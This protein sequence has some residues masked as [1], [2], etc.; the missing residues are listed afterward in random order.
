M[1]GSLL[2]H[3]AVERLIVSPDERHLSPERWLPLQRQLRA[4]HSELRTRLGPTA[5]PRTVY[6]LVANPLACTLGFVALPASR[7]A[8]GHGETVDAELRSNGRPVAVMVATAWDRPPRLMWRHCVHRALAHGV[9]WAICVNG[10]SVCLFDGDR[11]YSRRFL[12]LHLPSALDSDRGATVLCGLLGAHGLSAAAPDGAALERAI[13]HS[14]RYRSMVRLSLRAGVSQ[15]V[16]DLISAFRAVPGRPAPGGNGQV[17]EESLIVVYRMLFMLFAEARGLVPSWHPVYRDSYSVAGLREVVAGGEP[18][19]VWET[20]QALARLAHRGCAAGTLMV[21]P[22]NGRLFSPVH[23]PLA[24]TARLDDRTV[25]SAVRAL[26]TRVERGRREEIA[27]GDLGVE[28]LGAVYEHLLDF[29]VAPGTAATATMVPTGRRKATGS[30]YTPRPLTE[31]VVRRVLGPVVDGRA[32]E[33]ILALRIL[34]PAMGSGA[35]LVAAC[36][37]LSTAY[38]AAL[39]RDGVLGAEDLTESDRAGFRR[40][41]AQRCL[42]GV[43]MNPMAVQLARLSL[44]LATLA[45]DK[46]LTFL[47]HRLRVGNSLIGASVDDLLREPVSRP[48]GRPRPLPLFPEDHLQSRLRTAVDVRRGLAEIP[49]DSL[50]QVRAKERNLAALDAAGGPLEKWRTAADLWCAAYLDAA[51]AEKGVFGALRD[52]VFTGRS[53]LP[54]HVSAPLAGRLSAAAAKERAFHWTM[55]FPEVFYDE[56]GAPLADGGFDVVLGN[57]PWEMLRGDAV[58]RA[59][60]IGFVK[61]SGQ[62]RLQGDGHANMYQLFVERAL[63]LLRSAGSCG[64]ILPSGFASDQGSAALRRHVFGRTAVQTFTIVDNRDGLFPIHRALKFLLLTFRAPG[65]T[66]EVPMR[67]GVRSAD[68]LERIADNGVDPEAISVPLALVERVSGESLAVPDLRAEIDLRIL[69]A[70]SLRTPASADAAGWGLRF[71]RELNASDDRPHFNSSGAGLPVIEGKHL[72]PFRVD[73]GKA[74]NWIAPDTAGTLMD[75]A[76]TFSRPRLAYRDVA[77]AGNRLTLI[78]AI[79]PPRAVTTHTLF[80]LKNDLDDDAQLFLCGVLNSYVANYL[81]RMRVSTHVTTAVVAR[82]PVPNPARSDPRFS[83]VANCA[84]ALGRGDD[85]TLRAELNS[86]AAS[87]Y[88]LSIGEFEHVLGTFPLVPEAER[89]LALRC[90]TEHGGGGGG[91]IS[92]PLDEWV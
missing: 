74:R 28:Q 82:L 90:F 84:R 30:F 80:C 8:P 89:K 85:D 65:T 71:G 27:Y 33:E 5:G 69:S 64:L 58:A 14:E 79:V 25:A 78:A 75:P 22:F 86:A 91:I 21:P 38:E 52:I 17:M 44:W 45:A 37:Y 54:G 48:F 36:R 20:L 1:S 39:V 50:E 92:S 83:R 2:S 10:P 81:V 63:R 76:R 15:A 11:A 73:L 55:E 4:W 7:A 57:P 41:I 6:D 9:R 43:D 67:S 19:G 16:L 53:A 31:F 23:A 59:G 88:E 61:G 40:L 49:D 12:Q 24:D 35:F 62:Y 46:P 32:P 13:A 51:G 66:G 72:G 87:L 29:D 26:T 56:R 3:D 42:Y 70:I 18:R 68:A 60:L 34:D 77:A 47:D